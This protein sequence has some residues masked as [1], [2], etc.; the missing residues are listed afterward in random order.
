MAGWLRMARRASLHW[1]VGTA[2]LGLSMVLIVLRPEL[3][4]WA[5][6][7]LPN[8]LAIGGFAIVRRGI[9]VFVRVRPT[10]FEHALVTVLGAG[11][12]ALSLLAVLPE[13][14]RALSAGAAM[15]WTLLRAA[16]ELVRGL[17]PEF[18]RAAARGGALPFAVVG[19]A[20]SL[21]PVVGWVR[22]P[23]AAP[24][25]T[26]STVN[27]ALL[28]SFVAFG[29]LVMAGLVVLVIL[30]MLAR[31]RRLGTHDPLT[32]LLN[33]RGVALAMARE[34]EDMH[35]RGRPFALI[36]LDVDHFKSIND[37]H[38]HAVGDAALVA[39]AQTLQ[40]S[41]RDVDHVGRLG[42]E[43]FCVV[44]HETDVAGAL[45]AAGRL[46]QAVRDMRP[47][48][49]GASLR[50]TAS[51]GVTACRGPDDTAEAMWQRVDVALYEAKA[52]GRDRVQLASA[53]RRP[54]RAAATASTGWHGAR[55]AHRAGPRTRPGQ[56]ASD[57]QV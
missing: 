32:G 52:S 21:R 31:L 50:L 56:F 38:G 5:G 53:E 34:F 18:G 7:W 11:G 14:A 49:G 42:G 16:H 15:S 3:D 17:T 46:L 12:V 6:R 28:L 35:R 40:A 19:V 30:R 20:I 9:Q 10:D 43:E 51:F 23:G 55:R 48:A 26:A 25:E 22:G 47:D 54:S 36:S 29:Q 13:S 37:R 57:T 1:A 2:L 27:V 39:L 44:L 4:L 24:L 45:I 33:R 41:A 8:L